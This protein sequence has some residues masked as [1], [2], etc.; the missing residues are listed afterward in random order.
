M[1]ENLVIEALKFMALGMGVVF[2]FLVMMVYALKIQAAIIGRF[3]PVEEKKPTAKPKPTVSATSASD[4][5]NTAK[6]IAAITAVIQHHNNIK[7]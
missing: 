6:K 5:A 2:I 1:E 7:G 3:F 4:T